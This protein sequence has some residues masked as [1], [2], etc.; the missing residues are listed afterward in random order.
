MW[1]TEDCGLRIVDCGLWNLHETGL[2]KGEPATL[3]SAS[4]RRVPRPLVLVRSSETEPS[5]QFSNATLTRSPR[6]KLCLGEAGIKVCKLAN[7]SSPV[8]DGATSTTRSGG[9]SPYCRS[10]ITAPGVVSTAASTLELYMR[11]RLFLLLSNLDAQ[12]PAQIK[13]A[14]GTRRRATRSSER[15]SWSRSSMSV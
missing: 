5:G 7:V 1:S 13:F 8:L 6:T 3:N 11:R 9:Y 15:P 10:I 12:E 4:N 14:L 2:P